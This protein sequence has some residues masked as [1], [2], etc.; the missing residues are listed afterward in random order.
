MDPDSYRRAML[1][2]A[3]ADDGGDESSAA[4]TEGEAKPW[5]Y[6]RIPCIGLLPGLC[7]PHHDRVQSNGVLRATDFD[8]MLL[9]HSGE[10]G[11]AIDHWA[12]LIIEGSEYRV[13]SIPVR[14]FFS[15]LCG[16]P[17]AGPSHTAPATQIITHTYTYAH[18]SD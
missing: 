11:I 13:L 3:A 18:T 1:G 17:L 6:I 12:A 4:A 8:A 14:Q 15:C 10:R 2:A 9:R 5:E 16:K 7:C